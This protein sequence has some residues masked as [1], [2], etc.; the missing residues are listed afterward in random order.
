MTPCMCSY[1]VV[2]VLVS[3][4]LTQYQLEHKAVSLQPRGL[5]NR[6]NYCYINATLQALIACPPFYNLM[7]SMPVPPPSTVSYT[8]LDVYKRQG[9]HNAVNWNRV[10]IT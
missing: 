3:E 9:L 5:T 7:K 1:I 2:R 6:S 8:H 4:F 10:T